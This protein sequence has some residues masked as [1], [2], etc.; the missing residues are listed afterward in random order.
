MTISTSSE[1]RAPNIPEGGGSGLHHIPA[2]I[3]QQIIFDSVD[4]EKETYPHR[5]HELCR[6]AKYWRISIISNP[7]MWTMIDWVFGLRWLE[8]AI[9]RSGTLPLTFKCILPRMINQDRDLQGFLHALSKHKDRCD[10]LI[11]VFEHWNDQLKSVLGDTYSPSMLFHINVS[12]VLPWEASGYRARYPA[13]HCN[14]LLALYPAHYA[15]LATTF[16]TN[17]TVLTI[18]AGVGRADMSDL[19]ALLRQSPGLKTLKIIIDPRVRLDAIQQ[20]D[21]PIQLL[22][23]TSLDL[24]LPR[25]LIS[26]MLASLHFPNCQALRIATNLEFDAL[27]SLLDP[28]RSSLPWMASISAIQLLEVG[29]SGFVGEENASVNLAIEF[30]GYMSLQ[31]DL[32]QAQDRAETVGSILALIPPCL[33]VQRVILQDLDQDAITEIQWALGPVESL[34]VEVSCK[35]A[36]RALLRRMLQ[37]GRENCWMNS[38]FLELDF[39]QNPWN[40]KCKRP[41]KYPPED[42]VRRLRG[43]LTEGRKLETLHIY[44]YPPEDYG[45]FED[46]RDLVGYLWPLKLAGDEPELPSAHTTGSL[47]LSPNQP[48][49]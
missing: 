32:W 47:S 18:S 19:L 43:W 6:V 17:L 38:R 30:E 20:V 42:L 1:Q 11:L 12:A 44:G 36:W 8:L 14:R 4:A 45:R 23:L 41:I 25:P 3:F 34:R 31:V 39:E 24:H 33:P 15:H 5:V 35:R 22:H 40:R 46:L 21:P 29:F 28:I 7:A 16:R 10:L 48:L 26:F 37:V 27:G 13:S 49:H 2:E 9:P